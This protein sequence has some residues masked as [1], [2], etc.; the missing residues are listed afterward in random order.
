[1]TH[2]PQGAADT[3][4]IAPPQPQLAPLPTPRRLPGWRLWLP[5]L[6]QAGLI[7]FVPAHDAY[8]YAT[9]RLVTLQT[10]PVDPYDLLRGY[11]QT[12]GYEVGN[13]DRLRKLPGGDWLDRNN[14]GM[15]YIVLQA[16]AETNATP[17]KPWQPVRLSGD[18][19]TDLAA[20]QVALRGQY[21]QGWLRFGLEQFYMPEDQRDQINTDIVGAREQTFVEAK[22]DAQGNA[23][24]V[25][26]WVRDRNLRF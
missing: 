18:R 13:L 11:S 10:M 5:L 2:S 6:I 25:S 3:S 15:V 23:V 9:G 21:N 16:P 8:T 26:L 20:N 12:L 19:P 24:L 14:R 7:A 4:R 22:V 17:P 1:M